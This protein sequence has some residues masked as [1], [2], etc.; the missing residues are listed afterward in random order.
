MSSAC[1]ATAALAGYKGS[2]WNGWEGGSRPPP[3]FRFRCGGRICCRHRFF[4][5]L[6]VA[7]QTVFKGSI[8]LVGYAVQQA[9]HFVETRRLELDARQVDVNPFAF[10]CVGGDSQRAFP[11]GNRV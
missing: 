7:E 9:M 11:G 2:C 5:P 8:H 3:S 1:S 4:L 6:K 10:L